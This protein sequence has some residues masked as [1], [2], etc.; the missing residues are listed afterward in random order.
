MALLEI[1]VLSKSFG[2]LQAVRDISLA[3]DDGEIVSLIGPNGAGKT[4]VFNLVTGY[5]PPS[6][7]RIRFAGRDIVGLKPHTIAGLG[8]VRTFQITNVFPAL[9]VFDNIVAAHYLK[10]RVPLWKTWF[11]DRAVAAREATA[12]AAAEEVMGFLGLGHRRDMTAENLA[13]GELRLLEL[14]IGLGAGPRMLLLD[15][16]AAGL[17]T[18]ESARL[19]TLLREIAGTRGITILIVEHD[20]NV[21]MEVSHRVVV[22]N[23]GEKIAEGSPEHVRQHE[24]VIEAYLGRGFEDEAPATPA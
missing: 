7:G 22:M 4:T 21:V 5:L 3:V 23:F 2:G 13:Y 12:H 11:R 8:L 16:P 24:Q 14:A 17:N 9:S 20:M 19:V 1:D 15:E 10:A 18:E 6:S